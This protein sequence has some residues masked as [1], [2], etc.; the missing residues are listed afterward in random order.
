MAFKF[1]KLEVWKSALDYIDLIYEIAALLPRSEEFNLKSQM[2]RAATSA[3]L[4]I[5]EGSTSQTNAEQAQFL[6]VAMRSV[7]ESVACQFL[8]H[9]RNLVSDVS[10]LRRAYKHAQSLT[11][12]LQSMRRTLINPTDLARESGLEYT[13][14]SSDEYVDLNDD[15]PF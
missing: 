4:N 13:V 5:A 6:K 9:R 10:L 3:A 2:V 12:Q 15:G 14:F 7:V 11:A 1:E 8:I